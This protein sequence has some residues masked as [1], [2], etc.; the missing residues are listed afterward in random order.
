MG[1]PEM[2]CEHGVKDGHECVYCGMPPEKDGAEIEADI[3]A[4]RVERFDS[5]P[6]AIEGLR[7]ALKDLVAALDACQPGI[8]AA[9][10]FAHIHG[11]R[12]DGP[13]YEVELKAARKALAAQEQK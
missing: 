13:T 12:Y 1:E 3:A 6:E 9:F 4:G 5:M 8:T 11:Q 2:Y 10:T 7:E